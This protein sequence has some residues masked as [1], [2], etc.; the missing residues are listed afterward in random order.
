M[1]NKRRSLTDSQ[2]G[3]VFVFGTLYFVQGAMFAYVIVF[4]N[5][6]LRQFGASASQLSLLNG[7][8][9]LP[10]VLKIF[11]GLLSDRVN[12]RG[13]GHRKPYMLIGLGLTTLST[14]VAPLVPP[15]T[16]F[17]LFLVV[18]MLIALGVA[19]ADTTIDGLA[20]D[21]T[22]AGER[23][24]V[25]GAMA[26][27]RALGIVSLSAIYGRIIVAFDW[28]SVFMLATV[29]NCISLSVLYWVKE[30]PH[31]T[32]GQPLSWKF[33]NLFWQPPIRRFLTYGILY[34]FVIY[35]A[36]AIVPLYLREDLGADLI[37]V[38]D[39]AAM[40]G[41][42][43]LLGGGLSTL[44]AH[45]VS[46]W[47][48]GIVTTIFVTLVLLYI[49][50][51]ASLEQLTF[52]TILWGACLA[53]AELIYV[54]LAMEKSDPRLG[55]SMFAVFMAISNI[56]T[57]AG[58]ATTTGLIDRF[59]YQWLF[60]GL[61]LFNLLIIPLMVIMQHDDQS[62]TIEVAPILESGVS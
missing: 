60:G 36:N 45:K 11:F 53:G 59:A 35:G 43:M 41:L 30:P 13:F 21:V 29:F 16:M 44:L 28:S 12:F 54:T 8:L 61:A 6:Y 46:I 42:G 50:I 38:G 40:A 47:Q 27:G 5:L 18:A 15:V 19:I 23:N 58:Q 9:L 26:I 24:Q 37:K 57:G 48:R 4:N 56:G 20:I 17:Y 55:A 49:A 25:Q 31:K 10:F 1:M 52:V 22:P 51:F 39:S 62:P 7:L 14:L 3:R 33:I 34:A 2:N 32:D